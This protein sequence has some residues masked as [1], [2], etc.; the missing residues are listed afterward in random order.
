[1]AA[2]S[3]LWVGLAVVWLITGLRGV[4]QVQEW[5]RPLPRI[6]HMLALGVAFG[7]MFDAAIPVRWLQLRVL[8]H[9]EFVAWLAF[10]VAFAGV[11]LAVWA[12]L[13]LGGNWSGSVALKQGHALIQAGPYRRVRHPI[14]SG[15]VLAMLGTA[16]ALGEIRGFC[17]AAVMLVAFLIKARSED[18][19]M[20]RTFGAEHD[21][22]RATTGV[23]LPRLR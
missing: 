22:Y 13:V 12:R 19:L 17:A 2:I 15:L 20:Q 18:N 5:Q 16:I 9:T 14:Y 11:A 23:L 3:Y 8:P 4:K 7:L 1:L 10:A 6:L 21:A